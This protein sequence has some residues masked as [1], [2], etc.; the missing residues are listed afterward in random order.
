[1][2]GDHGRTQE[3]RGEE[4]WAYVLVDPRARRRKRRIDKALKQ[5]AYQLS[6]PRCGNHSPCMQQMR[7]ESRLS[8]DELVVSYGET[9]AMPSL[10]NKLTKPGCARLGNHWTRVACITS[11]RSREGSTSARF[12][13]A[14]GVRRQRLGA[15][16]QLYLVSPHDWSFQHHPRVRC[17]GSLERAVEAIVA[18]KNANRE[19]ACYRNP[20]NWL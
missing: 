19:E 9:C 3:P 10:L 2:A 12:P 14:K 11:S 13:T 1:L 18:A 5:D 17:F 6:D 8:R 7:L 20:E 16:K 4:W 15:G